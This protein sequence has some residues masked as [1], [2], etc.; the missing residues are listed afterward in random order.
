MRAKENRKLRKI[1]NRY[2]LVDVSGKES[3][4]TNVYTFNDTAAFVWEILSVRNADEEELASE[5][6]NAY[7]VGYDTALAD[8]RHLAGIWLDAGLI[9]D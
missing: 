2:M 5:L 8:V 3:N 1:G 9:T 7:D 6:S 4:I